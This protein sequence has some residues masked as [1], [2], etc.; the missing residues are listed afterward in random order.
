MWLDKQVSIYECPADNKGKP[1]TF[2]QILQ[3][4]YAIDHDFY[5]RIYPDNKIFPKGKWINGRTNDIVTI[6]KLRNVKLEKSQQVLLKQTMQCFTPAALLKSKK[7]GAIEEINRTGIMQLDFDYADIKEYDVEDLKQAIF[8]LPFVA[9]CGLSCSGAGFYALV[10]IAEPHKLNDYA[11]HFFNVLLTKYGIKADTTKGRNVNDLRFVSC[12]KNM[13]IRETPKPL[14]I[15]KS[16]LVKDN[17]LA[18][19]AKNS[20][21]NTSYQPSITGNAGLLRAQL[22]LLNDV[23]IGSRWATVQKV[24]YTLGGLGDSAI[25]YQINNCI[26]SNSSFDGEE[27]KY[28]KC[29]EDCFKEGMK[30]PLMN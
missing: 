2:S 28:L 30:Q 10:S 17:K 22:K 18:Y 29:A 12:D 27:E 16:V 6:D 14:L 21:S 25:I 20:L 4:Q 3:K 11:E 24:S 1:A 7:K 26:K 23:M 5:Y 13:L 9:Y 15:P 8:S 19:K